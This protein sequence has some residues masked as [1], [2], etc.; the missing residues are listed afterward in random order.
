M[1]YR[2]RRLLAAV[3]AGTVTALAGCG[4]TGTGGGLTAGTPTDTE[5]S[6]GSP[7]TAGS[8]ES[9]EGSTRLTEQVTKLV[10]T[11]GDSQ[12]FFGRSVGVSEGGSTAVI[13]AP[14]DEN[15]NGRTAGSAYV[16]SRSS[17]EWSQEAKLTPEDGDE[18][19]RFGRTVTMSGDGRTAVIGAPRDENS[20][21]AGAGSAYVFRRSGEGWTQEAKLAAA[22]GDSQDFFGVVGVSRDG[23]TAVIGAPREEDPNG[24]G[25]GSAYIFD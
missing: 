21:G 13:G 12:D 4:G 6:G 24:A 18:D 11:D 23:S 16:F 14:F 2:R 20:N 15:P 10:A 1:D 25:A 8:A 3:R 22:D 17:G 9:P 5:G 7:E 19:D